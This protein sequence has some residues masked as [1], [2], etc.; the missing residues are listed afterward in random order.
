MMDFYQVASAFYEHTFG[1]AELEG[2]RGDVAFYVEE[3]RKAG[4]PVLD[5]AC[6][7][8]RV[9]T[10]VAEAGLTVVGLDRSP[11]MLSTAR[12]KIA[13]LPHETQQR[14][15]L[16][17]GDMRSFSLD[18][19]FNLI[20]IPFRSFLHLM[21]PEDQRQ[22]LGCMRDHLA[23]D[24][25]LVLNIFD[26]RLD[27][28]AAHLGP[29]GPA[30]QKDTEFT[31]PETGRRVVVWEARRYDPERQVLKE[32]RI[33]EEI[34]DDGRVVARTYAPLAARWVYR[35]EMQYLLELSGLAV[36]AL[37]G[38]Y[39]RGPFRSGGEQIWVTRKGQSGQRTATP[40]V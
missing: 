7:T 19:R 16:V 18:Q 26:P 6:G 11:A 15:E 5:L 31:H 20:M 23:D 39:E 2:E 22:A 4:S 9:L 28:I 24:G 37:Y 8:G 17:E 12:E 34:G 36:E 27:V 13:R 14:I 30:L 33:F 35:Y 10:P 25:R 29:R 21:T 1:R 3:A 32:D 40:E 38:D